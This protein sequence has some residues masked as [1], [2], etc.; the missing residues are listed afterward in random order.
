MV[1]Q[2]LS[3]IIEKNEN[4]SYQKLIQLK[5]KHTKLSDIRPKIQFCW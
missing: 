5:Q 3:I 4:S 2:N 1:F